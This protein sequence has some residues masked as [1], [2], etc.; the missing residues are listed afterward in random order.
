MLINML[1]FNLVWFG[2]VYWGNCF[3][4][5]AIFLICV[6]LIKL[7]HFKY[8]MR[9]VL[10]VTVLGSSIDNILTFLYVFQFDNTHFT[11]LWLVVL[12]ASFACT[13]CHSLRFLDNSRV[14]Q[15]LIGGL[16]SPLSYIAGHKLGAV[17]FSYSM[18]MTYSLLA[19]IWAGLFYLFFSLKIFVNCKEK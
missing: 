2:L 14:M 16:V 13:L 3:I 1:G 8:E 19:V 11:P 17:N 4:P 18:V 9:L 5:I 7:S 6:H 15:L 10:L 12:W